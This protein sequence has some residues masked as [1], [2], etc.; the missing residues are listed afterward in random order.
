MI[1][2]DKFE[3]I[4]SKYGHYASWAI[5]D[6]EGK[7]PKEN[8]GNLNILEIEGNNQLLQQLNPNIIFV[9]LNISRRV[10][11]PLGNFHDSQPQG[12]DYKIRYAL[13]NSPF[14][15]AYM[16]DIIKSFEEKV[17]EKMMKHLRTNKQFEEENIRIFRQELND[18]EVEYHSIIAFGN[19]AYTILKRNFNNEFNIFKVP[20]YSNYIGKEKYREELKVILGF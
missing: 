2:Y 17:S 14:W 4:K 13:N 6:K 19:D 7:K 1:D 15:G 11:I 12:M 10:E 18:L 8:V 16:T 9:G 5:W 20:H 3:S